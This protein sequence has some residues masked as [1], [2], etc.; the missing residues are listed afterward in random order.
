MIKPEDETRL[1]REIEQALRENKYALLIKEVFTGCPC[2]GIKKQIPINQ[3]ADRICTLLDK[4][5]KM[6]IG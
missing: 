3:G 6:R 1:F 5:D 4:L 2:N